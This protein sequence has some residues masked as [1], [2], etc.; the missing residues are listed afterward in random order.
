MNKNLKE[1][2][3][4]DFRKLA[5]KIAGGCKIQEGENGKPYPCGTCFCSGIGDLINDKAKEYN[6]HNEPADRINE[7]WRFLLQLRDEKY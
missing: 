5:I 4:E 7:V 6:K 2:L 3:R 1:N